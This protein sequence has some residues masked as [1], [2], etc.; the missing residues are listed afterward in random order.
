[1]KVGKEFRPL[2]RKE[3]RRMKQDNKK[4]LSEDKKILLMKKYDLTSRRFDYEFSRSVVNETDISLWL[5]EKYGDY[6]PIKEITL[7]HFTKK[8]YLSNI[9]KNGIIFGDVVTDNKE[10]VNCPNLTSQG[11]HHDPSGFL[12]N[13]RG[14]SIEDEHFKHLRLVLKI[15]EGDKNLVNYRW[16]DNKHCKGINGEIT[17]KNP[18]NNGELS[19]QFL[20]KGIVTPS[21]IVRVDE[22][23][24]SEGKYRTIPTEEMNEICKIYDNVM[25]PNSLDHLRLMGAKVKDFSGGIEDYFSKNDQ[26]NPFGKLYELSDYIVKNI[27]GFNRSMY[28]DT[29]VNLTSKTKHIDMFEI[30]IFVINV[31]NETV[32]SDKK[33]EMKDYLPLIF[34]QQKKCDDRWNIQVE[35]GVS[36]KLVG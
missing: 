29:I 14:Q 12:D 13:K 6:F 2:I 24:P 21:M 5:S 22:Y 23:N 3:R 26:Y 17:D 32:P 7:F 19:K 30:I 4:V 15:E 20:Y 28:V 31:Y 18:S 25:Y 9:M 27:K 8:M 34:N 11:F 35:N 33:I 16:F 36:L 1:M 10:G